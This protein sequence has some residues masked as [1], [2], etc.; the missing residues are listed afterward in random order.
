MCHAVHSATPTPELCCLRYVTRGEGMLGWLSSLCR[1]KEGVGMTRRT[2]YLP[3]M[4]AAAVLAG[5]SVALAVLFI[6]ANFGSPSTATQ[7]TPVKPN[8]V[9]ILTDDM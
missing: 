4:I 1:A 2:S 8:F 7:T 9:F 6:S 5:C 3:M